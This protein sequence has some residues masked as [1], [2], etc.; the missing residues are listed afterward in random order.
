MESVKNIVTWLNNSCFDTDYQKKV[1]D[2]R[3]IQPCP[4]GWNSIYYM[5]RRFLEIKSTIAEIVLGQTNA[6]LMIN[7]NDIA[8]I[9]DFLPILELFDSL[10]KECSKGKSVSVSRIIPIVDF[11]SNKLETLEPTTEIGKIFQ[12]TLV[13]NF[14]KHFGDSESNYTWSIST[15]LDPRYKKIHFK[16]PLKCSKG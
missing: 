1:E 8:V 13:K 9:E 6:P 10:T 2:L 3:L 14:E 7:G 12:T 4:T 5:L 16:S 15:L 11:L